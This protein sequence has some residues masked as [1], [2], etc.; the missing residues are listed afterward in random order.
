V[1]VRQVTLGDRFDRFGAE[2]M[3]TLQ[4]KMAGAKRQASSLQTGVMASIEF[5]GMPVLEAK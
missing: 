4:S 2:T 1:F 3:C 5:T